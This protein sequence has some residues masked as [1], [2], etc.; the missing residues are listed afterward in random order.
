MQ[1]THEYDSFARLMLLRELLTMK[2]LKSPSRTCATIV[3]SLCLSAIPS[4]GTMFDY[5]YRFD[6]GV[7]MYGSLSGDLNGEFVENV[8]AVQVFY[9][10]AQMPGYAV[11]AAE[12]GDPA[13]G[14]SPVVSF[15]LSKNNFLFSNTNNGSGYPQGNP[16][17]YVVP[18][19]SVDGGAIFSYAPTLQS[20]SIDAP[21][22]ERW[23]LKARALS[24]VPT[25]A[26]PDGG[27]TV[28]MLGLALAG[29]ACFRRKFGV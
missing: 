13:T 21:A 14:S 18:N 6:D 25:P 17:L 4:Y 16:Y 22:S 28:M 9:S 1:I 19:G 26:V 29:V 8:S 3:A 23:S 27:S 11:F 12:F 10:G 20:L 2:T 7:L 24:T 15:D 5:S